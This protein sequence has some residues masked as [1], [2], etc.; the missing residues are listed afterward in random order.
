MKTIPQRELRNDSGRILAEVAA[1]ETIEITNNGVVMAVMVPPK[2]SPLERG[3]RGGNVIP[4]GERIRL[5]DV[6]RAVSDVPL[7]EVLDDLKSE[8]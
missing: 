1:G 6:P 7:Q 2:L 3:R 5:R 4:A 8:R